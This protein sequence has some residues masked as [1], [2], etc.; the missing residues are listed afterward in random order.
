MN[1]DVWEF[2]ADGRHHV[3][4]KWLE[5]ERISAKDRA[6]LDYTLSRLRI[7]DFELISTKL[8]AGPLRG[9]KVSKLR[10]RCENRE[11]RPMLCRGPVGSPLDYTLLGGA[12][13]VEY[14]RLEPFDATERA[15]QNR[16]S[17]IKNPHWRELYPT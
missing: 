2:L 8:M 1:R 9:S 14:H 12:L 5:K 16:K 7:L 13:E 3:I 15:D 17:L 4:R 11:L 10:L 6:K